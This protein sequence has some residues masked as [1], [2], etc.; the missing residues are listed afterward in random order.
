MLVPGQNKIF[1]T[2]RRFQARHALLKASVAVQRD[3]E[4]A[5]KDNRYADPFGHGAPFEYRKTDGGFEL[6]SKLVHEGK[7]VTL[8]AG[9]A[10]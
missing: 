9:P 3:G 8:A 10:K 5:L 4:Q 6:K 1:L 7:P 2:R